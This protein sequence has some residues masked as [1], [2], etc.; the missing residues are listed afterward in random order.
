[1]LPETETH[2]SLSIY[3]YKKK[4]RADLYLIFANPVFTCLS[5]DLWIYSRTRFTLT[6]QK[7]K[8]TCQWEAPCALLLAKHQCA[9]PLTLPLEDLATVHTQQNPGITGTQ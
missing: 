1:M 7:E 2:L 5:T 8:L 9:L 3:I 6:V 4:D